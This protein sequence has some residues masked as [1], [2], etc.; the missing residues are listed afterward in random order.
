MVKKFIYTVNLVVLASLMSWVMPSDARAKKPEHVLTAVGDVNVS[1]NGARGWISEK[2][3]TGM[4]VKRSQSGNGCTKVPYLRVVAGSNPNTKEQLALWKIG[5]KPKGLCNFTKIFAIHPF[6]NTELA[7]QCRPG[8]TGKKHLTK[9][10][11]VS[12]WKSK[13]VS[14]KIEW[15]P[16]GTTRQ[17]CTTERYCYYKLGNTCRDWRTRQVCK[18]VPNRKKQVVDCGKICGGKEIR[19]ISRKQNPNHPV[20]FAA[21]IQCVSSGN[22][23]SNAPSLPDLKGWWYFNSSYAS[24]QYNGHWKFNRSAARSHEVTYSTSGI[25][26]NGRPMGIQNGSGTAKIKT[27]NNFTWI[28]T[29][30]RNKKRGIITSM[31]CTGKQN[32]AARPMSITGKCVSRM[33]SKH[34]GT[35]TLVKSQGPASVQQPPVGRPTRPGTGPIVNIPSHNI[36]KGFNPNRPGPPRGPHW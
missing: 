3:G 8:F 20:T 12:F 29:T 11:L 14:T 34:L 5:A 22:K 23:T 35:F 15:V 16:D 10:G 4:T 33:Y 2:R 28:V 26:M 31:R 9:T 21:N 30:T 17:D 1:V 19:R 6:S 18:T 7:S 25:G 36:G 13:P 27:G 32:A 24:P